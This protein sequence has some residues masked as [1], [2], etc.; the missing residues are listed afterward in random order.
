[1]I[2]VLG[3]RGGNFAK[4]KARSASKREIGVDKS[5]RRLRTCMGGWPPLA[6]CDLCSDYVYV[7]TAD[8]PF[9]IDIVR[10]RFEVSSHMP[11]WSMQAHNMFVPNILSQDTLY[12]VLCSV[13]VYIDLCELYECTQIFKKRQG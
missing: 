4:P 12:L 11:R 6:G 9:S 5:Y 3:G 1:M 13:L 7:L 2:R 10:R 8:A